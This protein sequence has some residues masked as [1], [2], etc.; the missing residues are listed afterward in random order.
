MICFVFLLSIIF[1][2]HFVISDLERCY[3][4]VIFSLYMTENIRLAY[5]GT[6]FP[7]A[8]LRQ[9]YTHAKNK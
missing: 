7:Q 9:R 4:Y 2:K 5:A 1:V 8:A 6:E 3:L